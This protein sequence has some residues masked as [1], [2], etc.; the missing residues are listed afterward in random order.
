MRLKEDESAF[1]ECFPNVG[2]YVL[3]LP[4]YFRGSGPSA[5]SHK[6]YTLFAILSTGIFKEKWGGN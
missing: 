2:V 4:T 1:G 6:I 5:Y 3:P